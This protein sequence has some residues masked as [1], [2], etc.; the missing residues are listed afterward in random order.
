MNRTILKHAFLSLSILTLLCCCSPFDNEDDQDS[1]ELKIT[2]SASA[3]VTSAAAP[4]TLFVRVENCAGTRVVWGYG[5]STCQLN[6]DVRIGRSYYPA[7]GHRYCTQDAIEL[8]LDA[9]E[10]RVENWRW[11]GEIM[12]DQ[13]I[14]TLPPGRYEVHGSAGRWVSAT[15]V[16]IEVL[17]L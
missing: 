10:S 14:V 5:S 13:E 16:R 15:S 11:K 9:G 3:G 17:Q 1:T 6:A 2:I 7:V 8:G 4:V 12:K